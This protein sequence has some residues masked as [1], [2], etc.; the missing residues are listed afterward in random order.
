MKKS[1]KKCAPCEGL[2]KPLDMKTIRK[3]MYKLKDWK[4]D[5]KKITKEYV[6]DN[7]RTALKFF[8]AMGKASSRE[9]HHPV[10][11]WVYNKVNID[12]WTHSAN[13]LSM[14]DFN[15]AK[16]FDETYRKIK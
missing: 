3:N 10:A 1:K 4:T 6:F 2:G 16:K 11:T 5:G 13:G 14:N 15:M 9:G 12:L 8:A 7:D